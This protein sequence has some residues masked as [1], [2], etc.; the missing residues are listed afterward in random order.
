MK[1]I[2]HQSNE[3]MMQL[4]NTLCTRVDKTIAN[5]TVK[6]NSK[7]K[8]IIERFTAIEAI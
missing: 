8:E 3:M 2:V 5:M 6:V 1:T 7:F 4:V